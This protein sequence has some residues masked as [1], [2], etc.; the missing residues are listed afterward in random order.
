MADVD[1]V[2]MS[3]AARNALADRLTTLVDTGDSDVQPNLRIW[4]GE[5]PASPDATPASGAAVLVSFELNTPPF[6]AALDG[7]IV[8]NGA[9]EVAVASA[10][11]EAAWFRVS[12][13]NGAGVIDG[14]VT[15]FGGEGALQLNTLTIRA[16]RVVQLGELILRMP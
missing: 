14:T 16:G 8:A 6:I 13:R 4:S 15:A 11:G 7:A 9:F 10:N 12:D 5:L 1:S 3:R 2:T